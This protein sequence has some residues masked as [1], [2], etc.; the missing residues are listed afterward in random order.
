MKKRKLFFV[1]A[2]TFILILFGVTSSYTLNKSIPSA[3][4]SLVGET[5]D[6]CD[7]SYDNTSKKPKE[8]EGNLSEIFTSKYLQPISLENIEKGDFVIFHS[9][10]SNGVKVAKEAYIYNGNNTISNLNESKYKETIEFTPIKADKELISC[11][12]FNHEELIINIEEFLS[13]IKGDEM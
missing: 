7:I 1:S 3:S 6:K 5:Y 11:F 12:R 13:L 2:F 9:K 4:F 8:Q 10:N